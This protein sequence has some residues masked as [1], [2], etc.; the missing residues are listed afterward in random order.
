[1]DNEWQLN[2]NN[3]L[4][5]DFNPG[6]ETVYPNWINYMEEYDMDALLGTE[7]QAV[8]AD[9]DEDDEEHNNDDGSESSKRGKKRFTAEQIEQLE[10]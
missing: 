6:N 5:M 3:G 9:Q 7:D 2:S 1:M 4:G 10:A 8:N